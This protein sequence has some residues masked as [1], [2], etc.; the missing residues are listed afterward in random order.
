MWNKSGNSGTNAEQRTTTYARN[1]N[2]NAPLEWAGWETAQIDE[3]RAA[4]LA[5]GDGF[6]KRHLKVTGNR[7][8]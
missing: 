1:T 2:T 6:V 7:T 4:A 8:P 5:S 3:L